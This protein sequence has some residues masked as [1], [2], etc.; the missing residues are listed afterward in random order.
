[1]PARLDR[2]PWARFHWMVVIGLGTVWILDGLEVTIVGS[3][4]ARLTEPGQRD[5]AQS[6]PG[7]GTAGSIYVAGA[8][9]GALFFGQLTD[10]FG[11][12]RLF[13][14][15]LVLYLVATVA[16]RVRVERPVL[17]RL[18]LLHR[19]GHRRRVRSDQLGDRRA[20]P[21][22]RTRPRGPD[23]QRLVLARR[24][25][26]S[27]RPRSSCSTPASSPPISAG[28]SP[29]ASAS[30]SASRSCSSGATCPRARAG[31]SSTAAR[32]RPSGSSTR[33]STTCD[34]RPGQE[35]EEP[36]DAIDVRQRKT[37]P[38]STIARWPFRAIRGA[39]RSASRCSSARRSSTTRSR[40]TWARSSSSSTASATGS[41]AVLLRALR[42]R[43]TSSG[44]CCS[45][46]CSTPWA[47]S[48]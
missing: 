46:A 2:L 30:C 48:R 9:V 22:P 39:P 44:R 16:T 19:R 42:A 32:R 6:E 34:A 38:F 7:I 45:G 21:R 29:S 18:P 26:R 25:G 10:R 27:R 15:T 36:R 12:K 14:L 47:A 31:C 23:Y 37:I 41:V 24:R 1:M 35:L 4:A 28:G 20:D 33:S 5:R 11:R 40:S 8:C 3:I 17:L 43:A 13:L